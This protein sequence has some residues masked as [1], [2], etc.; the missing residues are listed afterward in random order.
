[1]RSIGYVGVRSA[2][3]RDWLDFGPRVFGFEAYQ[4]PDGTVRVRWCDRSHRLAIHPGDS[5][6]LLYLGWE[7]GAEESLEDVAAHLTAAGFEVTTGSARLAADR[8]VDRL[9]YFDDPFGLRHEFFVGQE[10]TAGSYQGSGRRRGRSPGSSAW[11]SSCCG[12]P[13]S[14]GVSTSTPP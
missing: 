8:S 12:C 13:T 14:S 3:A 6:R 5:D 1:M 4:L 2:S 9:I 10:E 11:A 7:I